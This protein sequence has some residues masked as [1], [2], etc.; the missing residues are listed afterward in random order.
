MMGMTPGPL[1][2][3]HFSFCLE[4]CVGHVDYFVSRVDDSV[5]CVCG[6]GFGVFVLIVI[7]SNVYVVLLVVFKKIGVKYK[8]GRLIELFWCPKS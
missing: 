4:D 2:R 1:V 6:V 7:E 5:G 8:G 3:A